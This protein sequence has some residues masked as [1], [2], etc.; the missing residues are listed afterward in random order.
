MAKL[1]PPYLDGTVPSFYSVMDVSGV[2]STTHITI[3]FSLNKTV[4]YADIS[5]F[6]LKIKT[7]Q[8]NTQLGSYTVIYGLNDDAVRDCIV[9][10]RV[11]FDISDLNLT[12]GQFYK[13]QLAFI[14]ETNT[15]GY[16]SSTAVAKYTTK[17]LVELSGLK[18]NATNNHI[19]NYT[20]IYSQKSGDATEKMYSSRFVL[21]DSMGI[22]KILQSR[23]KNSFCVKDLRLK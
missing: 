15:V 16:Y 7:I 4:G 18:A 8:T 2:N 17:P 10:N 22:N 13:V 20:G 19:Y 5:G 3:P 21:K 12:V 6:A 9:N 23:R 11:V 14:D 1:Y